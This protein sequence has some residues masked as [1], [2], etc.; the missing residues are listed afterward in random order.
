[1]AGAAAAARCFC[2]ALLL[3]C[4]CECSWRFSR[5]ISERTGVCGGGSVV[6]SSSV[7]WT[8]WGTTSARRSKKRHTRGMTANRR[9]GAQA[10]ERERAFAS[11][12][13]ASREQALQ[14]RRGAGGVRRGHARLLVVDGHD[15]RAW[16]WHLHWHLRNMW[17]L[18][19]RCSVVLRV[20]SGGVVGAAVAGQRP[21]G[22]AAAQGG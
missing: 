2:C 15:L 14:E 5:T 16:H 3:P 13:S 20:I 22:D 9:V 8:T 19:Q 6:F 12:A 17:L 1:M 18:R 7:A 4:G 21:L 10:T 11:A